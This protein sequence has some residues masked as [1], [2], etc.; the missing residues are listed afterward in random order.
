MTET[1]MPPLHEQGWEPYADDTF[2]GHVA[3][4]Y[5]RQTGAV[6]E[7]GIL[8]RDI[9]RNISGAVHGGILMTMFDRAMGV[10]IRQLRPDERFATA[11][12]TT[13]FLRSGRIGEF[14]RFEAVVMKSGRNTVFMRAEA[15]AADRLVGS[16][17]AIF[18]VAGRA[19]AT[20]DPIG[21]PVGETGYGRKRS[22]R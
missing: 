1:T 20:E 6:P 7:F 5:V 14:I 2:I 9:H 16:A 21:I 13:D 11:S 22:E 19:I 10:Q 18:M 15:W 4:V 8:T 12:M 17:N 3:S